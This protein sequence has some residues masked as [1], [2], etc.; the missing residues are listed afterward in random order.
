MRKN[1]LNSR[2]RE[3]VQTSLQ[4]IAKKAKE[5]K[6]YRFCDLYRLINAVSLMDAWYDLNKK[7]AVGVDRMTA[8]EYEKNLI[9][10]IKNLAER[11][12]EKRYRAK[13][14]KRV[15]IPKSDGK[16]RPLGIPCL[17]DR[18]VQLATARI[19]GAIFEQDFLPFSYGYRPGRG[20]LDGVRAIRNELQFERYNYVVDVDIKGFFDNIDYDWI[21]R[22]LE[23]RINDRAFIRLIKKWLKAGIFDKGDTQKSTKGSPQGGIISPVLANIYLHYAFDLWMEKVV[24]PKNN[25]RT[26]MCR[27]ADDIVCAFQYKVEAESF[28]A[29]LIERLKKF[30]LE[31]ST[32]KTKII[33]FSPFQKGTSFCFLGFELRWEKDRKGKDRIVRRT[34]KKKFQASIQR[35]S[36]WIKKYRDQRIKWIL[37]RVNAI[38]RGHYNY[39]GVIG[40]FDSLKKYFYAIKRILFKWLNRRS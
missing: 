2:V 19:V 12:K 25:G 40:N 36:E 8:K 24:K 11:L 4:G 15:Y 3:T 17:E 21:I 13:L 18:L 34:A 31:I 22:M 9:E 33:G 14:V 32:E 37:D 26:C 1:M 29:M 20:A 7:A 35:F 6:K 28:Y 30:N 16:Q 27:Y 39:Y 5:D 23:Q 10:N 38:L